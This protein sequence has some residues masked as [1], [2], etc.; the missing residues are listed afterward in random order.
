M[1]P[2]GVGGGGSHV[3]H[4]LIE[5]NMKKSTCLKPYGLEP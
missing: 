1:A 4:R 5:K 3:L 2:L